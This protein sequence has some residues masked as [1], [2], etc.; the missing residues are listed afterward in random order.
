[1]RWNFRKKR[2]QKNEPGQPTYRNPLFVKKTWQTFLIERFSLFGWLT[3]FFVLALIYLIFYSP[4]LRITNIEISSSPNISA[5]TVDQKFIR[6]QLEQRKWLIF[7]QSNI[8]LFDKG[9]LEKNIKST[10]SLTSLTIDK[11]LPHTLRVAMTEKSPEL[12]WITGGKYYYLSENGEIVSEITA[13]DRRA[14]LP[15]IFDDFNAGAKPD[16]AVLTPEKVLFIKNLLNGMKEVSEV[17][18][19][20]YHLPTSL[21]TQ[22]N[23]L[24]KAG[25]AIYFDMSK[26]LDT[27]LN[28]LKR[29]L[30]EQST[31][32]SPPKEYIDVRL[33]DR[34]YLK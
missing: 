24:T 21:G 20:S 13:P 31:K 26:N 3:I 5:T 14:E 25:Y 1:M 23:V 11:K 6:W 30:S 33:G 10:Y 4:W 12:V 8:L 22:V 15:S 28:K 7:R 29:V 27:Q 9:W 16:Q 17:E 2:L 18:V 32:D 34:V 19:A